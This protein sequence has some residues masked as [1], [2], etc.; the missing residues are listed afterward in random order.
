MVTAMPPSGYLY[1]TGTSSGKIYS[2][3]GNFHNKAFYRNDL[4]MVTVS[5]V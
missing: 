1:V 5:E 2:P 4:V 3:S